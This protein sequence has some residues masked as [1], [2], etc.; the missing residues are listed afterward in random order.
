MFTYN[1]AKAVWR[2]D[3]LYIYTNKRILILLLFQLTLCQCKG[4]S[5]YFIWKENLPI[6]IEQVNETMLELN[7]ASRSAKNKQMNKTYRASFAFSARQS[8][9]KHS[10]FYDIITWNRLT[11]AGKKENIHLESRMHF[12]F[13]LFL[14]VV[15]S[16]MPK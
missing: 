14:S 2:K 11:R 10:L 3:G 12:V 6:Y 8:F 13:F 5:S 15:C 4:L 16:H 7:K 1:H 9:H